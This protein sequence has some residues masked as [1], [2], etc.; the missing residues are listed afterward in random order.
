MP[1]SHSPRLTALI[2]H[3]MTYP[4][5]TLESP[6]D[7]PLVKVRGKIFCMFKDVPG[8]VVVTGKLK[9]S[10]AE[11]MDRSNVEPAT[12]GLGKSGWTSSKWATGAPFPEALVHGWM[13]ESFRLVAPKKLIAQHDAQ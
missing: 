7:F 3:A 9:D 8:A 4:E 11:A 5:T 1:D 13:D 12:H 2:A 10:L 6:W